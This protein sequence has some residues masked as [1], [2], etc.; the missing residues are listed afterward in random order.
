MQTDDREA[1]AAVCA[2]QVHAQGSDER[3]RAATHEW[4]VATQP[5]QYSYHFSWIGLPVI[6]YPPDIVAVQVLIWKVKPDLCI[7]TGIARG[8]SLLLSASVIVALIELADA[9]EEGEMVDPSAPGRHVIAIDIDVRPHNRAA[10]ES[11]PLSSR[12][13]MI[14]GSS[15]GPDVIAKVRERAADAER[16]L[17]LLDSNHTHEHVLA[18]LH[19]YA[20]LVSPGSCCV[21][22]DTII[23]D[24]RADTYPDRPWG[25]GDNPKSA[26]REYLA[27]RVHR[28]PR[29]R[30]PTAH[31]SRA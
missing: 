28:G 18:E 17:V 23:E 14:G 19:A 24:M 21:V 4:M 29:H 7:E 31:Q 30:R 5:H 1:F 2:D 9:A 10:I 15:I 27:S 25:H 20:P 6:Q 8:G 16:V 26:V 22:F 12:F 13:S 3:V 11:H